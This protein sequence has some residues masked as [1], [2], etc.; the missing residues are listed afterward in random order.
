MCWFS[1]RRRLMLRC[2]CADMKQE[3][4]RASTWVAASPL[5]QSGAQQAKADCGRSFFLMC[6]RLKQAIRR[7]LGRACVQ[8]VDSAQAGCCQSSTLAHVQSWRDSTL[9]TKYA[10]MRLNHERQRLLVRKS[11]CAADAAKNRPMPQ[12]LCSV[13]SETLEGTG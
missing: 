3:A 13:G 9:L 5:A 6:F 7:Q 4:S 12:N 10:K 2:C 11:I 8:V 1:V